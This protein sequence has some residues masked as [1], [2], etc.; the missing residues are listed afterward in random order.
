MCDILHGRKFIEWN[1]P[2][3]AQIPRNFLLSGI[4]LHM[5]KLHGVS[6]KLAAKLAPWLHIIHLDQPQGWIGV[7]YLSLSLSG[8]I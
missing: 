5:H 2:S 1:P 6:A 8:I 4:R 7:I 3:H